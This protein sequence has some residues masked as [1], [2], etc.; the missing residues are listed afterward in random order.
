MFVVI[1]GQNTGPLVRHKNGR[2]AP[3]LD[4]NHGSRGEHTQT[5]VWENGADFLTELLADD[6][7]RAALSEE[8]IREKFDIGYH[9]KHVD[10]IFK[11]VFGK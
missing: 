9:T 8:E 1:G 5:G 6:E 4:T 2:D 7:V 3:S 10:T 11:R